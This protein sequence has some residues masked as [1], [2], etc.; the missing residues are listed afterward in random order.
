MNRKNKAQNTKFN[1][2]Y[3][4]PQVDGKIYPI[5]LYMEHFEKL[6]AEKFMNNPSFFITPIASKGGV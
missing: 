5:D 3:L 6:R 4:A 2:T 1:G